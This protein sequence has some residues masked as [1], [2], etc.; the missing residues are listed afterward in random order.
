MPHQ[1]DGPIED[2]QKI[3]SYLLNQL[4]PPE[5]IGSIAAAICQQ[6]GKCASYSVLV[7]MSSVCK[8]W[9]EVIHSSASLWSSLSDRQSPEMLSVALSR[10]KAAALDIYCMRGSPDF[11]KAIQPHIPRIRSLECTVRFGNSCQKRYTSGIELVRVSPNFP[12]PSPIL[13]TLSLKNDG[14][15]DPPLDV[16]FDILPENPT[17]LRAL[18]LERIPLTNQ[19]LRLMTLTSFDVS[20]HSID[21][22]TLLGFLAENKTLEHLRI[23]C[24]NIL[25]ERSCTRIPLP[26]IRDVELS[27]L[28]P[29]PVLTSLR[30]PSTVNINIQVLPGGPAE[31]HL[32][33]VLPQSLDGLSGIA[34][35][36]SLQHGVT[37]FTTRV[38]CGSNQ[39]GGSFKVQGHFI[40][41][42]PTDF[43]PLDLSGVR[44]LC[45]SE[46]HTV[47]PLF[48]KGDYDALS[49][50]FS[51]MSGL[52]TLVL[53]RQDMAGHVLS[54]VDK[55]GLLPA[56]STISIVSLPPSAIGP[57][58]QLASQRKTNS[59]TSDISS[60]EI[61]VFEHGLSP[62][63]VEELKRLGEIV[64][65]VNVRSIG[66][67][68]SIRIESIR[69]T[70]LPSGFFD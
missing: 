7:R 53:V 69:K 2:S 49:N 15:S 33:D 42:F 21:L 35:A 20:H 56:L 22:G 52:E 28:T 57:L 12:F 10:S 50:A 38:F 51:K 61:Q 54:M 25:G 45:L 24:R 4:L 59:K 63:V 47:P 3:E 65:S 48:C 39:V 27:S 64:P 62:N 30:L 6:P 19:L 11:V 16:E 14:K 31:P 13:E 18:Q 32:C 29:S 40:R 37:Q 9:R 70:L 17:S 43:R 34:Q 67:A 55:E 1:L 58:I 8:Y 26:N 68:S 5:I 60:V 44:E 46:A 66:W 23:S 41:E 36:T